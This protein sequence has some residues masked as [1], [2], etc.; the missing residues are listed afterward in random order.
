MS[1]TSEITVRAYSISELA[2]LYGITTKTIRTWLKP[3]AE[4][5]GE[6]HG[7]YFTTLQVRVIFD[8]LGEP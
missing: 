1:T 4:E 7:R 3:Y 6:K 2:V 8:K 5:I